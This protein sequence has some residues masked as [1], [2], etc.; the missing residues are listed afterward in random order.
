VPLKKLNAFQTKGLLF[1][2]SLLSC[3][4]QFILPRP[5]HK[6]STKNPSDGQKNRQ[7]FF[8]KIPNIFVDVCVS[9]VLPNLQNF[10]SGERWQSFCEQPLSWIN[11]SLL[12]RG[13]SLKSQLSLLGIPILP[14]QAPLSPSG[15][16][17][18]RATIVCTNKLERFIR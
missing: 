10:W 16:Y 2:F 3:S 8:K 15:L 1:A 9:G 7:T 14:H 13:G 4:D 17:N 18:N 12:F 11:L 6:S 5:R